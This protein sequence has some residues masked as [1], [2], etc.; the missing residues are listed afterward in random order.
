METILDDFSEEVSQSEDWE[1]KTYIGNESDY[2]LGAW[3]HQ[4]DKV[5][6]SFN[7]SAMLFGVGWVLH[8]RM[9]KFAIYVLL[10]VEL[11]ARVLFYFVNSFGQFYMYVNPINNVFNAVL[12]GSLGNWLYRKHT[13]ESIEK[14]RAL[15]SSPDSFAASLAERGNPSWLYTCACIGALFIFYYVVTILEDWYYGIL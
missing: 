7:L 2:Y 8:R 15:N 10:F 12:L 14:I 9:Y 3:R 11:E 4:S 6:V 5:F 1:L 13:I